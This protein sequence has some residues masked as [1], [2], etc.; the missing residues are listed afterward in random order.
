MNEAPTNLEK[1][2]QQNHKHR[3]TLAVSDCPRATQRCN[4]HHYLSNMPHAVSQSKQSIIG[5]YSALSVVRFWKISSGRVMR[6]LLARSLRV[7]REDDERR[8]DYTLA[9]NHF[10]PPQTTD[11]KALAAKL[12]RRD[13]N[14]SAKSLSLRLRVMGVVRLSLIIS[15][16]N[17]QQ[18]YASTVNQSSVDNGF[19]ILKATQM[20]WRSW[21]FFFT[22]L[23]IVRALASAKWQYAQQPS[24]PA[25]GA[26]RGISP[27]NNPGG[28]LEGK[29][30]LHQ[31]T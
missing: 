4:D 22:F 14:A 25:L 31:L 1:R 28:G 26:E 6:L 5:T 23:T 29:G 19:P 16:T 2:I 7:P 9:M 10:V 11:Y 3:R 27:Y 24:C 15:I 17:D 18:I 20:I 13:L 21:M 12:P 8:R 30:R